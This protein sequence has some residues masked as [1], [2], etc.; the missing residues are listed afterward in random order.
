M[1]LKCVTHLWLTQQKLVGEALGEEQLFSSESDSVGNQFYSEI[2]IYMQRLKVST[3]FHMNFVKFL[4]C[5]WLKSSCNPSIEQDQYGV[6][7]SVPENRISFTTHR[8]Q[9]INQKN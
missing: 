1:N 3:F 8:F 6:S 7:C 9:V 2:D 4:R 5:F